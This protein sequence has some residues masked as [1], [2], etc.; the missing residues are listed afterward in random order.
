MDDSHGTASPS[1]CN[2]VQADKELRLVDNV[3]FWLLLLGG[4]VGLLDMSQIVPFGTRFEMVTLARF[5][6]AHGIYANPFDSLATGPTAAYPPIYPLFLAVVMRVF[7]TDSSVLLAVTSANIVVNALV[8]AWL[9]RLSVLFYKSV[10][11]GAA[12]SLLWLGMAQ[13]MPAWDASY[14]LAALILFCLYTGKTIGHQPC[15]VSAALAG[16]LAGTLFLLNPSSMLAFLPW[17]AFLVIHQKTSMRRTLGHSAVIIAVFTIIAFAWGARNKQQVGAFV[18]RTN[19]GMTLY[20]S[21]NDCAK[22]SLR[23]EELNNC[24][25]AHH[26]NTNPREARLLR[27][28]GE[29]AY[30]RL[31]MRDAKNW[32]ETHPHRFAIL[33]VKRIRDFWFPPL[34]GH[35]WKMMIVWFATLLSIPGY[36]LMAKRGLPTTRFAFVALLVYPLMYYIVISDVR[37]RY[38][39][40]WLT[41]LP[42]GY[43]LVQLPPF[44]RLHIGSDGQ[45]N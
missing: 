5:V 29:V 20:A 11:P 41:L 24:H 43:F 12:A 10:W 23:A 35:P 21:N 40:L 2:S 18:A 14:T 25:Q 32:I 39:V 16:L 4:A 3:S 42:A 8:A 9:P 22:P 13:L 27:N 36:V 19:L 45:A 28:M 37:Y 44:K 17:M 30:D 1:P 15:F 34:T 38:P 33:T 31:R 7:R 6:E 26:P